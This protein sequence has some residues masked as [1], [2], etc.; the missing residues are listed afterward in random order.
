MRAGVGGDDDAVDTGIQHRL[1]GVD[2][3]GLADAPGDR[4]DRRTDGVGD[5]ELVDAVEGGEC[6]GV[7][8][9]DPAEADESDT[10][11]S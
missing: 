8:G 9:A 11:Q 10:H 6:V 3:S 1:G 4:I 7:E 5:D 2:G